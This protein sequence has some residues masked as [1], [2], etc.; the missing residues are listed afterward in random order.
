MV[1]FSKYEFGSAECLFKYVERAGMNR[2]SFKLIETIFETLGYS[3]SL[4]INP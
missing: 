1:T 4:F 2:G 3:L